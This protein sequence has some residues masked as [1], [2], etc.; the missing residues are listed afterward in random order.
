LRNQ[1]AFDDA[2]EVKP[3][4]PMYLPPEQ[5]ISLWQTDREIVCPD[6]P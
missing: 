2:F 1:T 3:T 4:D 5:R 6:K